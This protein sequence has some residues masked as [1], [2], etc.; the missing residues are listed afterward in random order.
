MREL[1]T[2]FFV[3]WQYIHLTYCLSDP[4]LDS[5]RHQC[6][7]DIILESFLLI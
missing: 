1:T 3:K 6:L 5:F 2:Y 4:F 7:N